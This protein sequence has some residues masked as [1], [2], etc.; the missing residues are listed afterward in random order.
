[1]DCAAMVFVD[2]LLN[3]STFSVVLL[4]LD[5]PE[6]ICCGKIAPQVIIN[7]IIC[8]RMAETCGGCVKGIKS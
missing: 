5:R 1:M 3:F 8:L 6:R 7:Y 2:E 4:E